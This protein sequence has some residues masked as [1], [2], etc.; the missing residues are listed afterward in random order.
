M[1]RKTLA[2]LRLERSKI[3]QPKPK[4]PFASLGNLADRMDKRQELEAFQ[5]QEKLFKE[6]A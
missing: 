1:D 2:N 5:L 4:N 6:K 3:Y